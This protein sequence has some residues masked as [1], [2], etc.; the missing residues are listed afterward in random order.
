MGVCLAH[1]V[2][3]PGVIQFNAP[4]FT[5][6]GDV[7]VA[8]CYKHTLHVLAGA[9]GA[10]L[11]SCGSK[12]TAPMQFTHPCG[13]CVSRADDVLVADSRNNIRESVIRRS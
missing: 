11:H 2:Q 7:V 4:A 10:M 1:G 8:N 5:A 9:N 12:G 6:D 3:V 13:V